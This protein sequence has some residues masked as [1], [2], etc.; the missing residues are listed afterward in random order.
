MYRIGQPECRRSLDIHGRTV[1]I[2][3]HPDYSDD[4]VAHLVGRITA[5]APAPT[6]EPAA[7]PSR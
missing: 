5:A 1:L 3:T 6:A 2:R 4:E 7:L